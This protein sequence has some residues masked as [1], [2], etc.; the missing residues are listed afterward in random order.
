MGGR[1]PLYGSADHGIPAL[2]QEKWGSRLS[3]GLLGPKKKMSFSLSR[4]PPGEPPAVMLAEEQLRVHYRA[5]RRTLHKAKD[6]RVKVLH[7]LASD[8]NGEASSMLNEPARAYKA[9]R[10]RE[11]AGCKLMLKEK[12]CGECN[13]CKGG[14]GC[15]EHHRRCKE[16][17]RNANTF[18]AGSVVTSTSSQFDLLAADLTK[19]EAVLEALRDL[20]LELEEDMDQLAPG[21]TSRDNPRFS[22]AGRAREL[23]DERN[24]L[25][26]LSVMLQLHGELATR[27]QEVADEEEEPPVEE[28]VVT[29]EHEDPLTATQTSRQ[30]I[31]LFDLEGAGVSGTE[32]RPDEQDDG[33]ARLSTVEE[34]SVS[35]G[36][37]SMGGWS[38]D[39]EDYSRERVVSP[40]ILQPL[41]P[42]SVTPRQESGATTVTSAT[43]TNP[44]TTSAV[45]RQPGPSVL[46]PRT[47]DTGRGRPYLD[48]RLSAPVFPP[49][50]VVPQPAGTRGP[51]VRPSAKDRRRS[52]SSDGIPR[53]SANEAERARLEDR[54]FELTAWVRT[55]RDLVATRLIALE[56]MIDQAGGPGYPSPHWIKEELQ[57]VLR[58]LDDTEKAEMET[59]KL[60]ARLDGPDT[61]RLRAQEWGSWF[62]QV[63]AK[64]GTIRGSLAQPAEVVVAAAVNAAVPC[65]R[66]G[67]FLERVKLPQF[68]GSVEDYGEFKC[69]FRELCSGE[70]YTGVI[71]LA[72][73]RTKL[74]RDAV[75]LL[76]G[77]T[78]P[79]AAWARLDETYGN[80][81]LQVFAALKRLRAFKPSKSAVQ[82]QVVELAVAVQRCLTVLRALAREEDFLLDRETLAEVVDALPVD[83][84][85]RWYHR[86]GVRGESQRE[87]ASNFL[88]WLEE[89]RADAVA[90]HLDSLA[91]RTKNTGGGVSVPKVVASGVGADQSVN[92]ATLIAQPKANAAAA[93]V[94]ADPTTALTQGGGAGSKPKPPARDE[95]TTLAQARDVA[96]RRK[97]NLEAKQLDK[98]PLCK[99]Q[100][101]YDKEWAK[102]V[103]IAKVKMVSTLLSSCPQFSAQP[104][105]Q[106]LVTVAAHAACPLCTS[107]EHSKHRVGGRELPDPKCKVVV[108]GAECGGI[109]G[110]WYHATTGNTGNLVSAPPEA[111]AVPTPGLFEVYT[112]VFVAKDG[113]RVPGTVMVD[114]GSDTDYV[115]H[116]FAESLGL[117]GEPQVCRIKVVDMD[118]RTV[119]TAKYELSVVDVDGETHAVSAQGL[120]S[121]TTLPPDP[122][123]SPLLHLLEGVPEEVLVRPQGRVDVLLGL[124]NSKLHGKDVREWGNLRL[125][126]GRLGCGWALRGTH[127]LLEFPGQVRFLPLLL[128]GITRHPELLGRCARRIP[129]VS[130]GDVARASSRVPRAS[131][132]RDN[133]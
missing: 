59:W 127:E 67:G 46:R 54:R 81:D 71:E 111:G 43:A 121:I 94:V 17:P 110:R 11:C 5:W 98:C 31:E 109:H 40:S 104:P 103:P 26:R 95:V 41:R 92:A 126:R 57:F 68:S 37:L 33:E 131:G 27:L 53:S 76:V 10:C 36:A 4:T 19:Y 107:W 117:E 65:Q 75:A 78:S 128:H 122:S 15:E 22:Q 106:K 120:G 108:A 12:A 51:V 86:R 20:D 18:H 74:P 45:I 30:L 133:S 129:D 102:V 2:P 56:E 116:G 85:Q 99:Q 9:E 101:E 1:N 23:D 35:P 34:A 39:G 124:R 112:A 105:D 90:M 93:P 8:G 80:E 69:Q 82:G 70:S 60:V 28:T 130:R 96:T 32:T 48:P 44:L 132:A 114:S 77:L 66:R 62:K 29:T 21:S 55:R 25:A 58:T 73:L 125:L 13:G 3:P 6:Y 61:R 119:D 87:K 100:H 118:Y 83:S 14:R 84:Q 38:L 91:R 49:R 52:Q 72:Q 89:E 50:L 24:H 113:S 63:M 47:M 123:L 42:R 7:V 64:V 88:L 115:R 79:E 16:W 97:A